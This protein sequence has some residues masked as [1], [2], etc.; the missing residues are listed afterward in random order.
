MTGGSSGKT[1][2]TS[3]GDDCTSMPGAV[4]TPGKS[5]TPALLVVLLTSQ[6]MEYKFVELLSCRFMASSEEVVRA[7]VG[8][9]VGSIPAL[10]DC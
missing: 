1:S 10:Q 2:S 6:N 7:Q 9:C 4:Q 3:D 8:G 5:W